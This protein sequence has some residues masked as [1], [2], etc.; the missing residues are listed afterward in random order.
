MSLPGSK[1]IDPRYEKIMSMF[2]RKMVYNSDFIL[3][4]KVIDC[5]KK[6]TQ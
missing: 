1:I 2:Q 5:T 4:F 3:R 6:S